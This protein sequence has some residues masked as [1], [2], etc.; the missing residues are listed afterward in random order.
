MTQVPRRI[1]PAFA[2]L[3]VTLFTGSAHAAFAKTQ[4]P[5]VTASSSCLSFNGA[6]VPATLRSF[7]YNPA[8]AGVAVATFHG[9]LNCANTGTS[10]ATIDLVTQI[11]DSAAAPVQ[12]TGPGGLRHQTLLP[13][14]SGGTN[15]SVTFNLASTRTFTIPASGPRT[16]ILKLRKQRMDAGTVCFLYNAVFTVIFVP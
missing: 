6:N 15:S 5:C 3:F 11:V 14:K 9:S 13:P 10:R 2:L 12:L 7:G 16:V 4:S 1:A 8:K